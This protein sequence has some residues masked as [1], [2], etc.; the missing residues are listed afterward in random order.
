MSFKNMLGIW[1]VVPQYIYITP[2][3]ISRSQT[4]KRCSLI[5]FC[6]FFF[7]H[8]IDYLTYYLIEVRFVLVFIIIYTYECTEQTDSVVRI[9]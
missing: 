1:A 3:T 2:S 8:I 7:L 4:Q 9:I 5:L 6:N